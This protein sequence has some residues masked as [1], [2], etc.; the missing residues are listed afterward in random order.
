MLKI[1]LFPLFFSYFLGLSI[2]LY[3]GIQ[4]KKSSIRLQADAPRYDGKLVDNIQKG[5][6]ALS[7]A[8]LISSSIKQDKAIAKIGHDISTQSQVIAKQGEEISMQ[9]EDIAK[10]R[11]DIAKQSKDIEDLK[12][13]QRGTKVQLDSIIM[14]TGLSIAIFA[15]ANQVASSLKAFKEVLTSPT[16]KSEGPNKPDNSK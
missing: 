2:S 16:T 3:Q 4:G 15:G 12:E 14:G 11:E 5:G 7:L 1:L 10:Q 6:V 13:M 8:F 9:R